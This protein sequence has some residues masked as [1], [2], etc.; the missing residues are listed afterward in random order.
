M[1]DQLKI[2][3][4]IIYYLMGDKKWVD[5][6]EL[7]NFIKNPPTSKVNKEK[8]LSHIIN[9]KDY[10]DYYIITFKSFNLYYPKQIS[11]D[12][13]YMVIYQIFYPDHWHYY[14]IDQTRIRKDDIVID[15]GAAEGLFTALAAER[16][17]KVY[18]IEPMRLWHKGLKE[19]LKQFDNIQL[20]LVPE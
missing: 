18:A 13:L 15:C 16:C 11:L 6:K 10:E 4:I 12:M 14:E 9:V 5:K 3:K 17:R 20:P 19:T 1:K 2:L 7:L 8:A